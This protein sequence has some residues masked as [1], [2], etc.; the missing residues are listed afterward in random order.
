[1]LQSNKWNYVEFTMHSTFESN[2]QYPTSLFSRNFICILF[3]L[4]PYL[5][6]GHH[7]LDIEL[8]MNSLLNIV[9]DYMNMDC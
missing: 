3:Y 2:V 8:N 1:V 5:D 6:I 7:M 9:F 4:L